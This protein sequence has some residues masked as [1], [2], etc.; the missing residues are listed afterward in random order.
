VKKRKEKEKIEKKRV[1]GVVEFGVCVCVRAWALDRFF[2]PRLEGADLSSIN[3]YGRREVRGGRVGW[4]GGRVSSSVR[5]VYTYTSIGISSS[6][7]W[8]V[9][10]CV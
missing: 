4:L 1:S 9:C 10:V 3:T 2:S 5:S 7:K 6:S 8:A